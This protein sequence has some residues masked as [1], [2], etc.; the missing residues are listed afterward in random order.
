MDEHDDDPES[1]DSVHLPV[2]PIEVMDALAPQ[3][4]ERFVDGTVG[5]GGHAAR[6]VASLGPDGAL[7]AMDRDPYALAHA[8]ERLAASPCPIHWVHDRFEHMA[9]W[10]GPLG[11]NGADGILLDLGV[12]SMQLDR[13][14]RGFSFRRDGPL[15]MRMD[16]G[17]GASAARLV[18]ELPE[19][20]LARLFWELGEERHARRIARAIVDARGAAP[21]ATTATLADVVARAVPGRGRTHP[22]T[23]IFQAL[24]MA[25]NDEL[26]TLSRGLEASVRALAIGGRLAVLTF[27]SLEDRRVKR[28]FLDWESGGRGQRLFKKAL[29]PGREECVFNRRSRSAKLRVFVKEND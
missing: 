27:H 4:G 19:E 28:T 24:R 2:M 13:G 16:P 10:L 9:R 22:A 3:S 7:L 18:A 6:I 12:S 1:D 21:I 11:W 23:R 15:D 25:V 20:E 8:R 17:R 5:L 14:E 26:G 29:A